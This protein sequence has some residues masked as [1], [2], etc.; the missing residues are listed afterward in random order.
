[1]SLASDQHNIAMPRRAKRRRDRTMAVQL[2]TATTA[3][4]ATH[5]IDDAARIFKTRI[6]VGDNHAIG[7]P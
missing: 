6:I 3:Q 7:Q 1:M 2:D 5:F 4:A